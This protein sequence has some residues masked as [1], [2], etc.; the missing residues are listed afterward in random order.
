MKLRALR[1]TLLLSGLFG[2]SFLLRASLPSVAT[3]TWVAA[4]SMSAARSGACTV[5]LNDG[6]LLISG[7]AD[8]NG[9]T[10]TA[11]LFS[12]TGS[13]SAAASM[14]SPRSHQSCAVLQDGR[15]LAVCSWPAEQL[16]AAE[17][18]IRRKFMIPARVPGRKPD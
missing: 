8:A 13:W 1:Y 14:N 6:R 15:V 17:L 12:T 10:A 11:D 16:R 2:I 4:G 3:G 18:Q 7:G 5:A 9:P